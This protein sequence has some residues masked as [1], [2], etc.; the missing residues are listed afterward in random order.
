MRALSERL[1]SSYPKLIE[2]LVD[3]HRTKQHVPRL[4]RFGPRPG[5]GPFAVVFVPER[6]SDHL[7]HTPFQVVKVVSVVG[8][9]AMADVWSA[10]YAASPNDR[11]IPAKSSTV[12][13]IGRS[14]CRRQS[15]E[16][17]RSLNQGSAEL[18]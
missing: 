6:A 7:C 3:R 10:A 13:A 2:C 16:E 17:Y 5:S 8:V 18:E 11:R 15:D 9:P 12:G 1:L 4:G 14:C